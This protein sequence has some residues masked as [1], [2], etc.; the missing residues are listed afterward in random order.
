M[1][2][3]RGPPLGIEGGGETFETFFCFVGVETGH[4]AILSFCHF[5]ILSRV[6]LSHVILSHVILAHVILSA[7]HFVS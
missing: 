5:V 2:R 3:E 7:S 1:T 4:F 6:I